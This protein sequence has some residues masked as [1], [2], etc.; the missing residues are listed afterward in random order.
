MHSIP[1][2]VMDLVAQH[3]QRRPHVGDDACAI[4][5]SRVAQ[6]TVRQGQRRAIGGDA[7][8]AGDITLHLGRVFDDSVGNAVVGRGI[9]YSD[10]A[11]IGPCIPPRKKDRLCGRPFGQQSSINDERGVWR[12]VQLGARLDGQ[13][14]THGHN[15]VTVDPMRIIRR[16]ERDVIRQ[17]PAPRLPHRSRRW[18]FPNNLRP[19]SDIAHR[20]QQQA[21]DHPRE[22]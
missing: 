13:G 17:S 8:A 12:K 5:A 4:L 2:D 3:I 21:S 16:I 18:G 11:P 14:D 22:H 10:R 19:S 1:P 9:E 15:P 6:D 20:A 7:V